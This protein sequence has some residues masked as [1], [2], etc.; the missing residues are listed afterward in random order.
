YGGA[1][2]FK[3]D[4]AVKLGALGLR[5]LQEHAPDAATFAD[6]I[7]LSRSISETIYGRVVEKLEREAV[8]DFRI[9]F[10][11]GYGNRPDEE[12]DRH[13]DLAAREVATG[14]RNGTLSPFIGIRIKP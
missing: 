7:G 6:A 14:M 11:D 9:D 1:H 12:E 5:A 3:S 8:E 4:T 2:L 10:E 13:T